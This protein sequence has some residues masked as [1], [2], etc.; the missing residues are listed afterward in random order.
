MEATSAPKQ[1]SVEVWTFIQDG[2][3]AT[4]VLRVD[5]GEKSQ[6]LRNPIDSTP[7]QVELVFK[8]CDDK[9]ET[10]GVMSFPIANKFS[11]GCEFAKQT[12]YAKGES[13]MEREL[14]DM[15]KKRTETLVARR[16]RF[17]KAQ[18]TLGGVP[19]DADF[20]A[21]DTDNQQ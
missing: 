11:Y 5:Q 20:D 8:S 9:N 15:E 10:V 7:V 14:A 19:R 6:V 2:V 17:D 3:T 16:Q 18:A 4:Y 13:P 12:I 21:N 1:E